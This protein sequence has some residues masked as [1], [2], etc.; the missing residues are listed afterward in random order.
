MEA[1]GS[2]RPHQPREQLQDAPPFVQERRKSTAS[3]RDSLAAWWY[4]IR[5]S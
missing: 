1:W 4:L 3:L 5:V 2:F